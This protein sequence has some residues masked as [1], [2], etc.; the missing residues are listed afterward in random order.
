MQTGNNLGCK[1]LD[2]SGPAPGSKS[3]Y[4]P[5]RGQYL[6][7]FDNFGLVEQLRVRAVHRHQNH[8]NSLS[9]DPIH[10]HVLI[11]PGSGPGPYFRL[12]FQVLATKVLISKKVHNIVAADLCFDA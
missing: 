7:D 10:D 9:I 12:F 2:K 6:T 5:E 8:Q 11:Q 1:H 4:A 3:K